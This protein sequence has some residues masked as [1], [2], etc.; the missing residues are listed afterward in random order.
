MRGRV[1]GKV[2]RE[3]RAD[4]VPISQHRH[5]DSQRL[6]LGLRRGKL[7]L[8]AAGALLLPRGA[9]SLLLGDSTAQVVLDLGEGEG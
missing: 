8:E 2:I 4:L 5:L 9:L 3:R 7:L 6:R 1:R